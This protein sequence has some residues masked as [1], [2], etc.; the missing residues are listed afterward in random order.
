[1][2]SYSYSLTALLVQLSCSRCTIR[3][4]VVAKCAV[5]V[6]SRCSV[7]EVVAVPIWV[8]HTVAAVVAR[9]TVDSCVTFFINTCYSF[10]ARERNNPEDINVTLVCHCAILAELVQDRKDT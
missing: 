1:M 5:V 7:A 6:E 4:L 10:S 3:G 8:V 2:S 9:D